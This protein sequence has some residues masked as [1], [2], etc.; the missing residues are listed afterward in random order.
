MNKSLRNLIILLFSLSI[1]MG[2]GFYFLRNS[3]LA[4]F[5]NLYLALLYMPLPFYSLV[6]YSKLT[7]QKIMFKDFFSIKGITIKN[8]GITIAI[9]LTWAISSIVLT[10]V[11][12]LI[13]P[14]F[15][16]QLITTNEQLLA[17]LTS[18]VG[19]ELTASANLPPTPL[20]LIPITMFAAIMAGLSINMVFAMG[21]EILWRGHL[22]NSL[23]DLSFIKKQVL[24]GIIW[25]LW[26]I[27]IVLQGHNYGI[28][29]GL[30]G[31]FYFLLITIPLSMLMGLL[32][33]KTGKNS[34]YAGMLHGMFNGF[35]GF[36]TLM[37]IGYN[38]FIGGAVGIIS[39]ISLLI[40]F[41]ITRS[42]FKIKY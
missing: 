36:F 11:L 33:E 27:P 14:S 34:I 2:I 24:I 39:I 20:L 6:I 23:S 41:L 10:F 40:T 9:F 3:S 21:E 26:H 19:P 12:G 5:G 15:W 35:A 30:I 13:N 8:I 1:L 16:G 25:G 17:N 38:P 4:V 18:M 7:K 32:M 29:N 37:V 22:Y 42:V 28:E 31:S